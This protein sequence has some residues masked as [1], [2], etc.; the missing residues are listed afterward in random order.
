M[1][2]MQRLR[3]RSIGRWSGALLACALL[4]AAH[5]VSA[6][7]PND[8]QAEDDSDVSEPEPPTIE[9]VLR[10][11]RETYTVGDTPSYTARASEDCYLTLINVDPDRSAVVLFPNEFQQDNKLKAG[12]E[13]TLPL[14]ES[15][16]RFRLAKAGSEMLVGTCTASSRPPPG[17][18]HDFERQRF[19]IVGDWDQ[20]LAD[21]ASGRA[22][23]EPPPR[24]AR[25]GR[26]KRQQPPKE[27]PERQVLPDWQVRTEITYEVR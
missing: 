23:A 18:R 16:Y 22:T 6:Q 10:T 20:H 7:A 25:R 4:F 17:I 27:E 2:L 12:E 8:M 3:G 21:V 11:D 13:L 26:G 9:L 19:T 15:P 1:H 5:H 14:P 24:T